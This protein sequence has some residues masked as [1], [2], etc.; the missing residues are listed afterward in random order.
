MQS[1][2][3]GGLLFLYS[4]ET[5]IK[6]FYQLDHL[7]SGWFVIKERCERS[8]HWYISTTPITQMN[9]W[10][11][12]TFVL[13]VQQPLYFNIYI[14]AL[15]SQWFEIENGTGNK[16]TLHVDQPRSPGP[17]LPVP[18]SR[19]A[20]TGRRGPWKRGWDVNMDLSAKKGRWNVWPRLGGPRF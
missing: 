7:R 3:V 15:R 18:T 12:E 14:C 6:M 1:N 9:V 4:E 10:I 5:L 13:S 8:R 2:L 17:F 11:R 19:S 16:W 20:G